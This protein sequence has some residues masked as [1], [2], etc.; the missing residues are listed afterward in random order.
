MKKAIT[1]IVI[2][3]F[4]V[5]L[6]T[7]AY[8]EGHLE[9][10]M[11]LLFGDKELLP[12]HEPSV[13]LKPPPVP[14][15]MSYLELK[16]F[17][18]IN[19]Q[20]SIAGL[21]SLKWNDELAYVARLYS[22]DMADRGFFGHVDPDGLIHDSRMNNKGIYYYNTSAEN[23]AQINHAAFYTY[24]ERTGEIINKTYKEPD[25]VVNDAVVG[26]MNSPNHR[27]NIMKQEFDESGMGVAYDKNNES[28][29]FTQLFVT[30][31]HCG[32]KGAS[33]CYTEGYLPWCYMPMNCTDNICY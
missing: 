24:V 3:A 14:E 5:L 11:K 27:E 8:N 32:Y 26:W 30:R 16:A 29:Y 10:L 21:I 25:D 22:K 13:D 28:F 20:R 33:C 1:L 2:L 17:V 9:G 15:N 6:L 23:L 19:E 12:Y 7:Y 31:V 18:K 4:L